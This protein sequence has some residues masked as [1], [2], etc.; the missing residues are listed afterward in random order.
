MAL[1]FHRHT[2]GWLYSPRTVGNEGCAPHTI[3]PGGPLFIWVAD[4]S[5]S[6]ERDNLVDQT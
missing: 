4:Y 3:V 6:I 1:L 5:L 2:W